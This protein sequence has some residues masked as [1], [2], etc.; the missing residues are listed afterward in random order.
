[1]VQYIE[2]GR[3]LLAHLPLH[4]N[5]GVCTAL[6]YSPLVLYSNYTIIIPPHP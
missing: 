1:M 4:L 6:E 3:L 2:Y 5:K